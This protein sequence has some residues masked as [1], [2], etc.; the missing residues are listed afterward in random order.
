MCYVPLALHG[1][2][3]IRKKDALAPAKLPL[4]ASTSINASGVP[5]ASSTRPRIVPPRRREKSTLRNT[6]PADTP[7]ITPASSAWRWP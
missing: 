1:A 5:N 6:L 7:T 4:S 3:L 2:L